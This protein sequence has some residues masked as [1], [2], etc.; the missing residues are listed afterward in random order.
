MNMPRKSERRDAAERIAK[1]V[2]ELKLDEVYAGGYELPSEG[3][4]YYSVLLCR[5]RALGGSI[6]VYGPSFITVSYRTAIRTLPH[7]EH[8]TLRSAEQVEEFLR[9]RVGTLAPEVEASHG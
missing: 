1:L 8:A 3:K 2:Y 4:N 9:T 7:T 6:R 5:A